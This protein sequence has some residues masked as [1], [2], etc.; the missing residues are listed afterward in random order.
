MKKV[1]QADRTDQ[2]AFASWCGHVQLDRWLSAD[3]SRDSPTAI[4]T[5]TLFATLCVLGELIFNTAFWRPQR[6]KSRD[7]TTWRC[8]SINCQMRFLSLCGYYFVELTDSKKSMSPFFSLLIVLNNL[9][10]EPIWSLWS[11]EILH[12]GRLQYLDTLQNH[13][14]HPKSIH[15]CL[16]SRH[17]FCT[18]AIQKLYGELSSSSSF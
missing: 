13:A 16:H 9:T 7:T 8:Y 3:R 14:R 10:I 5:L 15:S 18:R 1:G 12:R 6:I 4:H 17:R 11:S 2:A